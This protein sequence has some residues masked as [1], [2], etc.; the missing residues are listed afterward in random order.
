WWVAE[1]P[2]PLEAPSAPGYLPKKLSRVRF[3]F[4]RNTTCLI[5]FFP[6]K[7][8][9]P[10]GVLELPGPPPP[11]AHGWRRRAPATTTTT[12]T[13]TSAVRPARRRR[14]RRDSPLPGTD[15][16]GTCMVQKPLTRTTIS[17]GET[18]GRGMGSIRKAGGPSARRRN[19]RGGRGG[20]AGRDGRWSPA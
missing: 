12:T 2:F 11:L 16:L 20:R 13:R 8:G 3:S 10:E 18:R 17:H 9:R 4:T 14:R 1:S 19:R 5:G 15:R 7:L 6:V